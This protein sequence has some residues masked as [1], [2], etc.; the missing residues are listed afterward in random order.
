[1]KQEAIDM[2]KA[3]LTA[4]KMLDNTLS[5]EKMS[6]IISLYCE[7]DKKSD[8][9][10]PD[11]AISREE[12]ALI[13]NVKPHTIDYHCKMGRLRRMTLGNASRASGISALSVAEASGIAIENIIAT[14]NSKRTSNN[15]KRAA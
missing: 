12:A 13:F 6:A 5:N 11:F 15:L 1:M 8:N 7:N 4:M 9:G 14:L 3:T 2:L 10:Q